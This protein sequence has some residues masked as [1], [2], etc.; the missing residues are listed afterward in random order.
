MRLVNLNRTKPRSVK[1]MDKE[2]ARV[3]LSTAPVFGGQLL[4]GD[5]N[6]TLIVEMNC[7]V[8]CVTILVL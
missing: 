4:L 1:P 8:K 2:K 3:V 5:Y 6:F 7:L